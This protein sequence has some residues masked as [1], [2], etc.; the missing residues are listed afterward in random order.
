M[1]GLTSCSHSR[2]LQISALAH[3]VVNFPLPKKHLVT[4]VCGPTLCGRGP[5]A[6][7]CEGVMAQTTL[8][9]GVRA[10]AR[11]KDFI[12]TLI[13]ERGRAQCPAPR[14]ASGELCTAPLVC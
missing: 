9:T 2:T 13:L 11:E 12:V 3:V 1:A 8:D 4:H 7:V 10:G 5:W 6:R 14:G